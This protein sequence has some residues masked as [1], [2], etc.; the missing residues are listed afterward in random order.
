MEEQR[1]RIEQEITAEQEKVKRPRVRAG[2]HQRLQ[3]AAKQEAVLLAQ[4]AAGVG[5][6]AKAL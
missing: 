4:P 1:T 5:I 3:G 6:T 2:K